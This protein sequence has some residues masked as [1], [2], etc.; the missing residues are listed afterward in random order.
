MAWAE[1]NVPYLDS[2]GV[3]QTAS[4]VTVI[5]ANGGART[6]NTGWYLVKGA[7]SNN[8]AITING[9][10]N[11]I[12]EDSS[13]LTVTGADST[14]GI[15]VS[16]GNRLN[17]Y[18]QSTGNSTG[19]LTATGNTNAAG[20]GG[21]YYNHNGGTVIINGG[22][23]TATG[24]PNGAGIGGGSNGSGGTINIIGGT[25]TATGGS[26]D[27]DYNNSGAG[28]GGGWYG[29]G[30]R[31]AIIG[32]TVTATGGSGAGI[33]SGG[34]R[35]SSGTTV[36]IFGG[37]VTASSSQGAGIGG[38][39]SDSSGI[40]VT[41]SGG[42]V[43]ATGGGSGTGIG[44]RNN[45][46]DGSFTLNGNAVVFA[47]SI[48]AT[49]E[50]RILKNGTLFIFDIGTGTILEGTPVTE[51]FPADDMTAV[52]KNQDGKSGIVYESGNKTGFIEVPG[53]TVIER[54]FIDNVSYTDTKGE[55][56][57]ANN[58]TVLDEDNIAIIGDLNGWFLVIG[59]NLIRNA[60]LRISGE[61][62]IILED[63]S[64]LAVTGSSIN[65]GINVSEGN[66]LTIYAQSSGNNMGKLSA[67][68]GNVGAGIGGGYQGNGGEITIT[69]GTVM[70]TGGRAGGAGIGGGVGGSGGTVTISGGTV[71]ATGGSYY[72][73]GIGGSYGNGNGTFTLDGNAVVFASS[74][75]ATGESRTLESGILFIFDISAT[76]LEDTRVVASFPAEGITAAWKKQGGKNGITYASDNKTG[77]IEV[78]SVTLIERIFINNVSYI[79]TNGETQTANNVIVLGED[80]ISTIDYFSAIDYLN[81]WFLVSGNNLKRGSMLRISGNA[82]IILEDDSDLEVLGGFFNAGINVSEGDSL[83]IYAQST[84][85]SMGKLAATSFGDGAGIGSDFGS[86]GGKITI[87]GGAVTATS[88]DGAGIG[89][90]MGNNGGEITISGGTVTA[91]GGPGGGAGIGGGVG[92]SGGTV[93][94][95]GGTV[96]ATSIG[97][98]GIGGGDGGDGGTFTL[99]GNT[100][101]FASSVSDTEESRRTGGILFI[102]NSGKVYGSVNLQKDLEIESDYALTIPESATLTIPSGITLTVAENATLTN[103]GT[104]AVCG[105]LI[106][107]IAGNEPKIICPAPGKEPEFPSVPTLSAT[108]E[109]GLTLANI[110]L[111]E[112]YDWENSETSL[113]A[114]YG[115]SFPAK[116][117]NPNYE[118]PS[119]GTVTVD[120]AKNSGK[121]PS[122]PSITISAVYEEG[123]RLRNIS[124]PNGYSYVEPAAS[125]YPGENQKFEA[126]YALNYVQPTSGTLILNVHKNSGAEP[127]FPAISVNATFKDNLTLAEIPLPDSSYAWAEPSTKI[128]SPGNGLKYSATHINSYYEQ[129]ST[130]EITVNVAVG[131]NTVTINSWIYGETPSIPQT[132][133]STNG[134]A[135]LRY[136]GRTNSG[137]SYNSASPPTEAGSYTVTATFAAKGIYSEVVR[138]AQFA[139]ERAEGT[140]KV[141]IDG[142]RFGFKTSDPVVESQTNGTD[143]VSYIYRSTDGT[144]YAPQ[145]SKPSN[146][147][148]Y[149]LIAVFLETSNYAE[150]RDTTY[151]TISSATATELTVVWSQESVFTYNKMVQHPIPTVEHN[152]SKIP[153]TLLNA[154]SEV[155]KYS[156][157]LEAMA[158][159]RD[160]AS[161]RDYIL[162]NNTKS[163]E[164][165][166][167]PL[168]PRFT[169]K[170]PS[171]DFDAK[172][173][174]VW[175][176]HSIFSD[177]ALLRSTLTELIDYAG[178]AKDT[179]K[180]E[181]DDASVL[182]GAPRL[183]LSYENS[184]S[185]PALYRRVETTR[186]ATAVIVTEDVNSKNYTFVKNTITV[187][188]AIEEADSAPQIS[189]RKNLNCAAMSENS[190]LIIGGDVV[191]S[192]TMLCSV[193]NACAPM[194]VGSCVA[195]GGKIVDVC[196]S[197]PNE[198][199]EPNEPVRK[200]QLS[201]GSLRI[202]Q[203]A[204]GM[205]NVD[206][207]YMP[208]APVVLRVYDLKGKLIASERVNTRFASVA[209][210]VPSGVYLFRVGSRSTVAVL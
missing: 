207:G 147:G 86:N 78:P 113:F 121:E 62:H 189:C 128:T 87:S 155:G 79:D 199:N 209:V 178:F 65:A 107:T 179:V 27:T 71:T 126:I 133:T 173:D 134:A 154:Q 151:F 56:K 203:T 93:T 7:F 23:V 25:V 15:D 200:P 130:G 142:W 89:G 3:K 35:G 61:A 41:I 157:L 192:C 138:T 66:S 115:Q 135:S 1:D 105:T 82:H 99:D 11:L 74:V 94:I 67:T 137:T 112:G 111:P 198:P 76:I 187:M 125:V 54:I 181:S 47:S 16:E 122:F 184:G 31:V 29:T 124:L 127:T 13:D 53:V 103:Y 85:N 101:V 186:K 174:T 88:R 171:E 6:L 119:T 59:N 163:Y 39:R 102:G 51:H 81:G 158:I 208:A 73:A 201:G 45:S 38:G 40:V 143:N 177:T 60:T 10:V 80:N 12:L 168:L 175:V 202:W 19:K 161:R 44:G 63:D 194:P 4:G 18:A 131:T 140:G 141:S 8:G 136:T 149:M 144:S 148:D 118:L 172:E 176:P 110:T 166:K 9:T 195:M 116:H 5:A 20:I 43:T 188:E 83:T 120:V 210:N 100:V 96:T 64:D 206:L 129:P 98:A 152:G 48:S 204:S 145:P 77:F 167:K 55:T 46:I 193:D 183:E 146:I 190:C 30:G 150:A 42:T 159:I 58:V 84:G 68:G 21:G 97:G 164:I 32:G 24:G 197:E 104:I 185:Q 114:G 117:T 17:I 26:Y 123:L 34:G 36:T 91:T 106:G 153:L 182:S 14:A 22:E 49:G 169:V 165:I 90:C 75:N 191:A 205:V 95:T 180:N 160:E 139:I 57:T 28:I 52:W 72:D 196:P 162:K 109:E 33:G 156:G 2:S 108:Y 170:K 70:A 37:T 92:G 132:Q 69:G 50:N